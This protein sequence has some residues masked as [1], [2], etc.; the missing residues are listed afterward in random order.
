MKYLGFSSVLKFWHLQCYKKNI[1]I[2]PKHFK[3]SR[4]N[5]WLQHEGDNN[6][7]DN[8]IPLEGDVSLHCLASYLSEQHVEEN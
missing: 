8:K 2:L 7:K 3:A 6:E 4:N 5:I 1:F